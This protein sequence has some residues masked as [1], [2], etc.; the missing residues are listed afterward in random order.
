MLRR[1]APLLLALAVA[2][3]PVALEFCQIACASLTPQADARPG[4]QQQ[5]P[6]AA[7]CHDATPS[8]APLALQ[9]RAC[10]HGDGLPTPAGL[11]S[12]RQS[13]F[14][15]SLAAAI[16]PI[17][18]VAGIPVRTQTALRSRPSD[19]SAARADRILPLRI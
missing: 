4:A 13:K 6:H 14:H 2:G 3:A 17:D 19:R 12:A 18:S 15:T 11:E 1:I 8:P 10:D 9:G 16:E 5:V 7:A